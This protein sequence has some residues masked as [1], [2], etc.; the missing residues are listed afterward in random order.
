MNN[1]I[2]YCYGCGVCATACPHKAIQ[3]VESKEGFWVPVIDQALCI[4]CKI[5]DKVC[6]Y[7]DKKIITSNNKFDN[8]YAYAIINKDENILKKSTSGGAGFA[9]ATYLNNQGYTLVGVKYDSEKNIAC[10]FTTNNIE[11]FKQTMNS[12]YIQSY[13]INGFSNLMDGKQYAVFGTPCQIESLRRWARLKKKE[14]NFIFIDLF[15]HGVPSYLHW[16]SYL[17]YHLKENEKLVKPIFRDKRN[18]W[19][20]YTM[21][22]ETDKR[23]ISTPLQ[24]NDF[25]QN[26]F[27]GNFSLN[28]T[29]YT[30]KYRGNQ[31]AADIRM[32][33]LW[34]GK[35]AKNETGIT[36]LLALTDK[37]IEIV[38]AISEQ[39]LCNVIPEQEAVVLAGQ[40][41]HNLPIPKTR[42]ALLDGF[43]KE[44]SLPMLYFKYVR[45][46]WMKNLV[47]YRIK[48][49]IKRVIYIIKKR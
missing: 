35:Y 5:C 45:K 16:K 36:G 42:D 17:K 47:P 4:N 13:T 10:H 30:C 37:G 38:K 46:M 26:I 28:Q 11:E 20:V 48:S 15:C 33:D 19:H 39:N 44:K 18:G 14:N 25:F 32:G 41:H 34:G 1:K 21:S 2:T 3:I 43:R 23:T 40:L 31:S 12:K 8:P 49:F 6:A 29:C 27:F 22:L 7:S 24:K 9:I